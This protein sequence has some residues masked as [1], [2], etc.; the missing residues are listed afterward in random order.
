[1]ESRKVPTPLMQSRQSNENIS[2]AIPVASQKAKT[3]TNN[4]PQNLRTSSSKDL[5]MVRVIKSK[6]NLA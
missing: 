4:L 3:K 5:R 6:T 1:M 2:D